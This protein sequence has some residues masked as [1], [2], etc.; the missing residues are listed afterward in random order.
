MLHLLGVKR[1]RHPLRVVVEPDSERCARYQSDKKQSREQDEFAHQLSYTGEQ[2]H[3]I[4]REL[5]YI[6]RSVS[7]RREQICAPLDNWLNVLFLCP[8]AA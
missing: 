1:R 6:L 5:D 7:R 3:V 2:H 4:E 8:C